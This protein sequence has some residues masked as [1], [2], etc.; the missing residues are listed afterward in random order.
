MAV[1]T[2]K[3]VFDRH[4]QNLKID[5]A[6][7]DKVIQFKIGFVTRNKDYIEFFS[8]PY[9]HAE[10]VKWVREREETY[11]FRD[12]VNVDD[13][14]LEEELFAIPSFNKGFKVSSDIHSLLMCYLTYRTLTS[15]L[16]QK[17]KEKLAISLFEVL[18]YKFT[19]SH[20]YKY[21]R[22]GT[23]RLIATEAYNRL[24]KRFGMKQY[25]SWK[26]LLEVRATQFVLG[27]SGKKPAHHKALTT[28]K[29]D[30]DIVKM[31]ND[32]KGRM[33]DVMQEMANVYYK[34]SEDNLRNKEKTVTFDNGE[35]E[36]VKAL[37]RDE[38]KYIR[39]C[40]D[41]SGD[42]NS[43][44]KIPLI[45]VVKST[46]KDSYSQKKFEEVLV[47]YTDT[48]NEDKSL[49]EMVEDILVY[50][51]KLIEAENIPTNDLV[52]L[53]TKIRTFFMHGRA[54]D[55]KLLNARKLADNMIVKAIPKL[56]GKN[57]A[58]ERGCLL[59][60]IVLRTMSMAHYQ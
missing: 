16:N 22:L 9:V 41:I 39:Y 35:G 60:Y 51:F 28:F 49:Q 52:T 32:A 36:F 10:N 5:K 7:M 50:T 13:D 21:F 57:V 3:D 19:T 27:D 17:D 2:I 20:L 12:I 55:P 31:I 38:A 37:Q 43:F 4:C 45:N 59:I 48:F 8:S 47:Y 11:W 14:Y 53:F 44:V 15:S 29:E 30:I 58:T 46:F 33:D 34:V 40:N 25:G 24:S 54:N 42:F 23:Q 18:Y 26:A 1:D 6:F 56:K